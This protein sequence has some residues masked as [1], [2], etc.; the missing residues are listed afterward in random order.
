MEK[1]LIIT[2]KPD[3]GNGCLIMDKQDNLE[4]MQVIINDT[5]KFKRLGSVD[6]FENT[7]KL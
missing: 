5:S 3:K 7:I 6:N 4:K 2:T 1:T